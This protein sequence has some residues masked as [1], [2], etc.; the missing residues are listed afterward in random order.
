MIMSVLNIPVESKPIAK[1]LFKGIWA[2][3]LT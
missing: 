3:V 2:T 1:Y